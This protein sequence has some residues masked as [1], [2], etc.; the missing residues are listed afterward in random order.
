MTKPLRLL[1]VEDSG[2]DAELVIRELRRGGYHPIWTRVATQEDFK[3]ALQE[4]PWDIVISDHSLPRYSGMQALADL[5]ATGK[6]LPFIL[7]SGTI[8]ES[9]AVMAMKAGAQDYVL[10]GDLT[11]LPAAVEREVRE[12]AARVEQ[13]KMRQQLLI[14][15][16]MASCGTLAAGVAHEINN[17]LAVAIA[18]LEYTAETMTTVLAEARS[19]EST[20]RADPGTQAIWGRIADLGDSLRDAREALVRIRNIVRDVKVF[21]RPHDELTELIDVR[22][23]LDSSSRMAWTEIRHRATLIKDYGDVPLVNAN[24]SRV[25]QLLL[26]LIVNAAQAIREGSATRNEI[27]L[28]TRTSED[29]RAI[30]EV[31]DTGCGISKETMEHIFDPFFTTKPVGVGTGLGLSICHKIVT[32]IG[33][34]IEVESEPNKG[35][36]FRIALPPARGQTRPERT[37]SSP[38]SRHGGKVLVVDD[39]A[40][41]C[42]ALQRSLALHHDV[43]ALTSAKEALSQIAEG[44]RFDVIL[45]DLMMPDVTGMEMYEHLRRIAPDQ[46]ERMIFLTGGAFTVRAREF[47]DNVPNQRIEKPFEATTVLAMIAGLAR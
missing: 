6:Y 15:E 36:L 37:M 42:R 11:R 12:A 32:E 34:R 35:A 44:R 29:G 45:T 4:G 16:R 39:E 3:A 27:R 31:R 17:P 41:I 20:E 23:A 33:G 7:M 22:T 2:D 21:S 13:A 43:V 38:P 5:Q 19:S 26:N 25:G 46:A 10:K 24:P 40:A 30:I 8:G 47:L 18:N 9:V 28:A 14:S 1:L